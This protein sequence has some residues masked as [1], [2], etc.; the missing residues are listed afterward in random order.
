MYVFLGVWSLVHVVLAIQKCM[1][2]KAAK[3]SDVSPMN[4]D[5]GGA[6]SGDAPGSMIRQGIYYLYLLFV[7]IFAFILMFLIVGNW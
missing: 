7:W 1:N 4:S 5:N 3:E 2:D 6:Q